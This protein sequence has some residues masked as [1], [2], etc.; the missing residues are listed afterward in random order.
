MLLELLEVIE[1]KGRQ[2][3]E[4]KIC[5][6]F[7]CRKA[8]KKIMSHLRRTNDYAQES[9]AEISRIKELLQRIKFEVEIKLVRGHQ[10]PT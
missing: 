9:G 4:G 1:A 7:D 10:N 6:G 3:D 5:I 2:I 8:Y